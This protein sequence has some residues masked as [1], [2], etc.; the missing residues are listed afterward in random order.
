MD[1][2]NKYLEKKGEIGYVEQIVHSICYVKGLPQAHPGELVVFESGDLGQVFSLNRDDVEVL[3][4]TRGVINLGNRVARTGEPIKVAVGNA[5]LGRIIDSLGRPL[6]GGGALKDVGWR[7]I[8]QRPPAIMER[9]QVQK[10]LETGVGLVDTVVPLGKGQR[11]LVIGDRKTGK[12]QFLLQTILSQARKGA[13]C[14]YAVIGQRNVDIKR[15]GEFFKEQEISAN[16]IVVGSSSSDPSGLIFLTPYTAM[17]IAEFFRDNGMDVLLILDD[18]T[19]HARYYREI[20]LLAKRFPGRSSYPGD[21]FYIHARL[22]ER[23]GN[24]QKGSITCLPSAESILGDLSG[25]IQTNIM[26]MTD[27]HIYF[28]IDLFTQGQRP[29]VNPFLSVT[30]VGHQTQTPLQRDISREVL[31][32]LVENERMKSFM[33]FGAE[34]GENIRTILNLGDRLTSFFNQ[35]ALETVPVNVSML[36]LA[37]LWTGI[38]KEIEIGKME[39]QMEQITLDYQTDKNY[40]KEVDNFISSS[41]RFSQLIDNLRQNDEIILKKISMRGGDRK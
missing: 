24:F 7:T 22:L 15:L 30:R 40:K 37:G 13:V 39:R 32:F 14:I 36:I 16:T 3:L 19:S 21:I 27:G 28:D 25:Y 4:L 23:A 2:F 33:H 18:L 8:S 20:S 34:V 29:A 1:D 35:R 10:P 12:T 26:A 31:S 11:E 9:V 6:D 5:L 41:E 17:T 38:W